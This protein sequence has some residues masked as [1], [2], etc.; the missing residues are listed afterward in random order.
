MTLSQIIAKDSHYDRRIPIEGYW[1]VLI[2]IQGGK[3][4][5]VKVTETIHENDKGVEK[6]K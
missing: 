4:V 2:R 6:L 1:D 5:L 3:V